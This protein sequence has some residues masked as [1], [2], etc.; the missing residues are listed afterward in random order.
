LDGLELG[1]GWRGLREVEQ[2]VREKLGSVSVGREKGDD[3]ASEIS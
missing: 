1:S 3:L 2:G